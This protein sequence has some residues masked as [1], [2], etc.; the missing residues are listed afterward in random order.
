MLLLL[1]PALFGA[2]LFSVELAAFSVCDDMEA[3]ITLPK[4][5]DG[6]GPTFTSVA[7]RRLVDRPS[8]EVSESESGEACSA[9]LTISGNGLRR[10]WDSMKK[11]VLNLV[12]VSLLPYRFARALSADKWRGSCTALANAPPS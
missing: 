5:D 12:R 6:V 10:E 2:D 1:S 3:A 11:R 9:E 8:L 4:L 7:E